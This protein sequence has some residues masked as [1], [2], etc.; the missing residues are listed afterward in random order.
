MILNIYRTTLHNLGC[1]A[2]TFEF[3]AEA[4]ERLK[5]D[6]PDIILTDLNMPDLTGIDVTALVR[7]TYSKEELP[8]IMVTT[9]SE[10]K[11]KET[12]YAAGVNGILQKPFTEEQIS[13]IL[14][15]F[16]GFTSSRGK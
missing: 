11:D 13:K 9:Q 15:K 2:F 1:E 4:L 10:G 12:A 7:Q 16:A 14:S 5:E 8:I 6:K 3:P